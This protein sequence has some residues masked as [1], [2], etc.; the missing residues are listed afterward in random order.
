MI[1]GIGVDSVE[2]RR[3]KKAAKRWGRDLLDRLFTG[4]ELKY[5]LKHADPYPSLAA[6]FAAKEAVLKA[7]DAPNMWRWRDM[8]VSRA[9]SGRPSVVLKGAAAAFVRR[10][11]VRRLHVTLTHD[12]SRATAMVVAEAVR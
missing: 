4:A 10:R 1:S 6:R 9:E 11:G 5:C 2:V 12:E 3:V 7:L 8:E